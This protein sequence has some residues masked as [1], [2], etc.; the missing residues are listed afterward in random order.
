MTGMNQMTNMNMNY[1]Q[2]V[3]DNSQS[4]KK[5]PNPAN[6]K[7]V[8]CKNFDKGINDITIKMVNANME[9][10]APLLTERLN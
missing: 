6:F 9:I 8:K 3:E 10:P 7:I 4:Q 2:K 5:V 1:S